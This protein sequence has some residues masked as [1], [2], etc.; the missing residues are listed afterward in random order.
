MSNMIEALFIGFVT[1]FFLSIPIGP[2]NLAV[3][4]EAFRKGFARAVLIGLGGVVADT[5]YC[6]T[7]FLGFSPLLSKI[8]FLWPSLQFIGGIV[9]FVIGIRY[10][11]NPI[12]D[13]SSIEESSE[14]KIGQHFTKAFPIGFVMGI[15]NLGLFILWGGVNAI[16]VSHGW[17][18]P[19]IEAI[20]ICILGIFIGSSSWF[21]LISFLVARMH[22]QISS[23][24]I[25]KITRTGGFLLVVFG[26]ILCYR[27]LFGSPSTHFF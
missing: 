6:A 9:V 8:K 22:R 23:E 10:S 18:E 16:F 20:L 13:P 19:S 11:I 27:S 4:N 3:I 26:L 21:V 25:S 24:I 12:I 17:I 15:S 7:A 14:M 5:F 2:I 1:G